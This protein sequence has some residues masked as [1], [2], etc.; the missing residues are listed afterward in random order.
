MQAIRNSS[1]LK[2][3]LEHR[4]V[5]TWGYQNHTSTTETIMGKSF[6]NVRAYCIRP[7]LAAALGLALALT[8]GCLEDKSSPVSN[9]AGGLS[10][11]SGVAVAAAKAAPKVVACPN[12]ATGSSFVS[13]G[14]QV[15]KTAKIG[16]QVWMAQNLNYDVPSTAT[17]VCYGYKAENCAKYGRLYNWATAM[18]LPLKCNGIF[19]KD[20]KDCAIKTPYH[21]GICPAGWHIPRGERWDVILGDQS[22]LRAKNGWNSYEYDPCC[23]HECVPGCVENKV[24]LSGNGTDNYGFAALPGGCG[25][26]FEG[27]LSFGGVGYGG[28]WWSTSDVST[29]ASPR[30]ISSYPEEDGGYIRKSSLLSVRCMKD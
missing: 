27:K 25:Y 20:D 29:E 9:P 22:K 16:K 23:G 4:L 10:S 18:A 6:S 28:H 21:Q 30:V 1:N 15:Y 14:G 3:T 2:N 11:S 8:F 12:A 17:D 19:S 7:L 5:K 24:M 13:C 26:E